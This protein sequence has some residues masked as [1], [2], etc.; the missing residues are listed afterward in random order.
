MVSA[1]ERLHDLVE[2]LDD[3]RA[4]D[5]LTYVERLTVDEGVSSETGEEPQWRSGPPLI[6]GREFRMQPPKDWRT[7]AA[8]QGIRPIDDLSELAGDFWPEDESIDDFIAAVRQWR[9]EGGCA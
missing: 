6:S 9:R 3:E 8:E 7:F 2:G 5:A 1:K 4:E